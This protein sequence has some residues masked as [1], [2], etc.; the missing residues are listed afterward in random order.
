MDWPTE[1]LSY[2]T[3]DFLWA[4]AVLAI[5][6]TAV[7]MTIGLALGLVLALMRISEIRALS[8]V[9]LVLYLGGAR[10]AAAAATRLR[11]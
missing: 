5:Q 2:F 4:G 11:L 7:S 8:L 9:G 3:S 6:I 1:V 10:H